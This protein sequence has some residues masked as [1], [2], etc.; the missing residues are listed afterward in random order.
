MG[1]R[2]TEWDYG[3]TGASQKARWLRDNV[4]NAISVFYMG[5]NPGY[6]FRNA[7]NN[8]I[9][10]LA[11]GVT[12]FQ[13]TDNIRQLW[14]RWGMPP[15][16]T[17]QG[18]G[19]AGDVWKSRAAAVEYTRSLMQPARLRE[20]GKGVG[21]KSPTL[22][23]G[24]NFERYASE[25]I[26]AHHIKNYWQQ[27]WPR[28]VRKIAQANSATFRNLGLTA[29]QI[30]LRVK[31][32]ALAM[33]ADELEAALMQ[34]VMPGTARVTPPRATGPTAP[35]VP[36]PVKPRA[37]SGAP[38]IDDLN[39]LAPDNVR[40]AVEDAGGPE[41]VDELNSALA[42]PDPA[43]R[44]GQTGV[45]LAKLEN[46]AAKVTAVDALDQLAAAAPD[47]ANDIDNLL[48]YLQDVDN[49]LARHVD[50]NDA[51]LDQLWDDV[52][53]M[54][55]PERRAAW[56]AYWQT[57]ESNLD[58]V[59]ERVKTF[60]DEI[61]PG[62]GFTDEAVARQE[63]RRVE[64]RQTW[65]TY[66]KRLKETVA[67]SDKLDWR[68][69]AR[70]ALW[71]AFK[72]ERTDLWAQFNAN[73]AV[74]SQQRANDIDVAIVNM[75]RRGG[76]V[77]PEPTAPAGPSAPPAPTPK[78]PNERATIYEG[79][80][81]TPSAFAPGMPG[82]VPP[83]AATTTVQDFVARMMRGENMQSPADLEFYQNN[84]AGHRTGH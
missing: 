34:G 75:R 59:H 22:T 11:D 78:T 26:M 29:E 45:I 33:N 13:S 53:A 57:F 31:L 55:K 60:E 35:G 8:L 7:A 1:W 41:A 16:A 71:R 5:Y 14:T 84:A 46:D 3:A 65:S 67:E 62:L 32:A 44:V 43:V 58:A 72:Q 2:R 54:P 61:M 28:E 20:V 66:I 19:V 27:V 74:R 47:V 52:K 4:N 51:I 24:Q 81:P 23:L 42:Q 77:P 15:I 9:T 79:E 21:W 63:A 68:D 36:A 10:A 70:D 82:E 64:T 50:A 48:A 49:I 56:N 12:P 76:G 39:R 6:A 18:I 80:G 38:P 17:K 83:A 69:P 73:S 40:K 25:R 37:P 30:E